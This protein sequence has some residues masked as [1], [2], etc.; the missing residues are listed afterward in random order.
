MEECWIKKHPRWDSCCCICRYRL[1]DRSH[2]NIDGGSFTNRRGWI[3]AAFAF[4][5]EGPIA[6]SGWPE[7]GLCE[8]FAPQVNGEKAE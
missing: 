3:C 5:G 4:V 6:F 8:L 1:E 7:H 2:P